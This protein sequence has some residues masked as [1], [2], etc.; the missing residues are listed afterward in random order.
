MTQKSGNNPF[1]IEENNIVFYGVVS[2]IS[3][4]VVTILSLI[5]S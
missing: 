4:F 3:I 5:F 1:D 2:T